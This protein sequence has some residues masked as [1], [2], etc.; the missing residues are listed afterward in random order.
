MYVLHIRFSKKNIAC[1]TALVAAV[2]AVIM[3][4][5]GCLQHDDATPQQSVSAAS[6]A[7]RVAYLQQQGWE[8]TEE[9]VEMLHLQLPDDLSA[10]YG[11]YCTLQSHQ[12]LPFDQYGGRQVTRYTY[13]VTNYPD[14]SHGVQAN[15]YV[16]DERIIAGDIIATGENGFQAD[17]S[18][19]DEE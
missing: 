12:G 9:P 11:D 17:L 15:L 19:P 1:C 10:D 5:S 13:T 16:C 2:T 14:I 7:D 3:L 18:F 4:L 8:V 6:N